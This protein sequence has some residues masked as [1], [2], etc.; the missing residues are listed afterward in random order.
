MHTRNV[1][2]PHG[3]WNHFVFSTGFILKEFVLRAFMSTSTRNVYM[4]HGYQNH[5][6]FSTDFILKEFPLH[7][8]KQDGCD[9]KDPVN[10]VHV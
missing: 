9:I 7:T 3:Y 5:F 1:Y 4:L 10:I 2:M 8:Q 6:I